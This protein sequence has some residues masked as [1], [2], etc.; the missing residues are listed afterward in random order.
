MSKAI[1]NSPAFTLVEL[2]VAIPMVIVVIG[3]IVGL[4]IALVGNVISSNS[5]NQMIYDV[6]TAL[7]QIEQDAF[8]ST[9]F[10]DTYSAPTP[11][12]KSDSSGIYDATPAAGTM[13]DIVFNQLGTTKNPMDPTRAVSYYARPNPCSGEQAANDPFFIKVVYFVKAGTLYKR[14]IVPLNNTNATPDGDTVCAKPWQRGS[15]TAGYAANPR[16]QTKDTKMIDG[17][18]SINVTYFNKQSP[19]VPLADAGVADSIRI[20]ISLKRNASGDT[21]SHTGS[22]SATRTNSLPTAA[23]SPTTPVIS[24]SEDYPP[25]GAIFTWRPVPN[26]SSYDVKYSIDNGSTWSAVKN[27][28][29]SQTE[30]K[31]NTVEA[32]S[33][34]DIF[35]GE[36]VRVSVTAKNELGSQEGTA[37][38][39]IPVWKACPFSGGASDYGSGY[40]TLSYTY[41]KAK[42]VIIKGFIINDSTNPNIRLCTL[43]PDY[44]PARRV[45]KAGFTNN[46]PSYTEIY[47]SGEVRIVNSE[48][49]TWHTLDTVA[50]TPKSAGYTWNTLTPQGSWDSRNTDN[51]SYGY[52]TDNLGRLHIS[53]VIYSNGAA[54][55]DNL[56]I[57][58]TGLGSL[59]VPYQHLPAASPGINSGGVFSVNAIG[60]RQNG[61]TLEFLAK[62]NNVIWLGL[63]TTVYQ[64]A[65]AWQN[66]T[67]STGFSTR[68]GYTQAQYNLASD[69]TVMLRGLINIDTTT[70]AMWTPIFTLPASV[71]PSQ[72]TTLPVVNNNGTGTI[73]V[74]TVSGTTCTASI[75]LL[76][77]RA[78]GNFFSLDGIMWR[79]G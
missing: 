26:A 51:Y 12:M 14:T 21:Y 71:C 67:Y 19:T 74:S 38:F 4:M 56:V 62:G 50:Y 28:P 37:T 63:T 59:S 54:K 52:S 18:D 15:C 33:V 8:L 58:N 78:A 53:A 69:D 49:G 16:C 24:L 73:S 32:T 39:A 75:H 1:K 76:S 60:L 13:P 20:T 22:L 44:A 43:P 29:A 64:N 31:Y 23:A 9:S 55:T 2:M 46:H 10:V 70:A 48:P 41:T 25:G 45:L 42:V 40:S 61:T 6:Q 5:K 65:A 68:S 35:G 36:S 11:Q 66:I 17:V 34:Q 27:V 3:I 72:V 79:R 47:A 77:R 57:S 7:N 30:L